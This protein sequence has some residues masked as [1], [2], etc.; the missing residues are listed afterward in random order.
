VD[1]DVFFIRPSASSGGLARSGRSGAGRIGASGRAGRC[2]A[3]CRISPS[4]SSGGSKHEWLSGQPALDLIVTLDDATSAILSAFLVAE[5]GTAST[6]R[7]LNEVFGRDGLPLS[8]YTDRGSHFFYTPEAGGK[9]DRT[10]LTQV[11]RALDHLGVEHIAGAKAE[12][13]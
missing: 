13:W 12:S 2:L 9:V 3:R 6:F 8:L 10:R 5:E 1:E 11:G 4:T 7:A